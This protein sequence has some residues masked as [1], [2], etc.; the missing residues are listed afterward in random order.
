LQSN[1]FTVNESIITGES[2]PADKN[3]TEKNN[4]IYQGTTVNTGKCIARVT[5]TG[6]TTVLGKLGI[7]VSNAQPVKTLLQLQINRFVSSLALFGLA[8]FLIIF[9]VNY[10]HYREW[11]SSLL[12]ALTLAMSAIPEE[13]PVAFSSFM[14]LGAHKMS[15]L[16]IISRQP[17]IIENL[18]AVSV[19]CLDKT[20]TITENNMQVKA[21]YDYEKRRQRAVKPV[22]RDV[23]IKYD[24]RKKNDKRQPVRVVDN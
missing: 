2:L 19:I 6:N 23:K 4:I 9:F 14:A 13:I 11:A 1:D 7:E 10:L 18:G 22:L 12:F 15:K 5:A 8:G 17:Q 20:G 16:G 24:R 21:I 3:N